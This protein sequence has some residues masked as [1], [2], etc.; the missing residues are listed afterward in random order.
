MAAA[1]MIVRS[2]RSAEGEGMMKTRIMHRPVLA[3]A[4]L[5]MVLAMALSASPVEA[6]TSAFYSMP[7]NLTG[8]QGKIVT[9]P[10]SINNLTDA[11]GDSGLDWA[12]VILT[13]DSGVFTV[14]DT[15][16]THGALLTNPPPNSSWTVT[17]F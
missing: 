4:S 12:D 2:D 10:L 16:I 14:S 6:A 13:Y 9:V 11:S 7:T 17:V 15:D 5:A 1:A 3:L 8:Q